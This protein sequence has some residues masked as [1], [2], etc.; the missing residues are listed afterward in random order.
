MLFF[1]TA[2]H[3]LVF[4][5]LSECPELLPIAA[6]WAEEEWGYIRNKGLDYRM[7]VLTALKEETYIGTFNGQPVAMFALFNDPAEVSEKKFKPFHS[8]EL[9]YVYVDK[10]YRSLGFGKQIVQKAKEIARTSNV[11]SIVLDTL[12]PS[13]NGF[14]KNHGAEVVCEGGLFSHPTDVL[15][16]RA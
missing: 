13:L 6:R 14:Y 5:K 3:P 8:Y 7:E 10:D 11:E 15:L 4:R 9:M 16:L 2:R 1:S 12:K